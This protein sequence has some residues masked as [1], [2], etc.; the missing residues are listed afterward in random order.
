MTFPMT[1]QQAVAYLS[2]QYSELLDAIDI[3]LR[4]D[5]ELPE[6]QRECERN[7]ALAVLV[8][9]AASRS[10]AER[11]AREACTDLLAQAFGDYR[12]EQS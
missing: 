12:E 10:L 1:D 6:E 11:R 9:H 3:L 7:T 8:R 4:P 2:A 5:E